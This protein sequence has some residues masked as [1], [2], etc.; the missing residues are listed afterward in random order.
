MHADKPQNYESFLL[1]RINEFSAQSEHR[2][3]ASLEE[4]AWIMVCVNGELYI[5]LLM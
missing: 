2:E 1:R 4:R 3:W 5:I